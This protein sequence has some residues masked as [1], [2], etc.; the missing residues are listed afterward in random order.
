GG[1]GGGA[2]AAAAV[3][4]KGPRDNKPRRP[5]EGMAFMSYARRAGALWAEYPHFV[6]E[7]HPQTPTKT[8]PAS[9]M[10]K[11]VEDV[12]GAKP[13]AA[14]ECLRADP[15][16]APAPKRKISSVLGPGAAP[17]TSGAA[18]TGLGEGTSRNG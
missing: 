6:R 14:P 7:A 16:P 9:P 1:G 12:G 5:S 15:A 2:V 13:S 17:A 10:N 3:P 4:G 8:A 11:S 18:A